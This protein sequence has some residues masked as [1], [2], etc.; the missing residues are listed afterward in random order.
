MIKQRERELDSLKFIAIFIIYSLHFIN[1]FRPIYFE[2]IYNQYPM[3]IISSGIT[4][5]MCVALFGVLLGYFAY[6]YGKNKSFLEYSIKR[7]GYFVWVGLIINSIL[8][9]INDISINSVII[10]SLKVN[11]DIFVTFWFAKDFLIASIICNYLGRTKSNLSTNLVFILIS[12]YL[13]TVW[14]TICLMGTVVS[15]LVD[16]K[17][18]KNKFINIAVLIISLL[19]IRRTE[20]ETTYL[21]DGFFSTVLI[22]NI[23]KSKYIK[24]ILTN[25]ITSNLGTKTMAILVIHP[26]TYQVLGNYLFN[27]YFECGGV[28]FVIAW[29]IC[30]IAIVIISYPVTYLFNLYGTLFDKT[31]NLI[32]SKLE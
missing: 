25:R 14:I 21:L 18:T 29:I 4:G 3:K 9:L 2:F 5:K 11:S 15:G 31:S 20:S 28:D 30:L 32:H 13:G 7:Y 27:N 8:G 10:S 1:E 23:E 6:N 24:K 12:Y 16:S 17:L 19:L 26:I 22:I